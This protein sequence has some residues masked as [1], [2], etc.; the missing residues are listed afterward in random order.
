MMFGP[1]E[2]SFDEGIEYCKGQNSVPMTKHMSTRKER[3]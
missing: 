1:N 2:V 3:Q